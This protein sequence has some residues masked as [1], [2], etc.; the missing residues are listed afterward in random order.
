MSTSQPTK[1]ILPQVLNNC[2]LVDLLSLVKPALLVSKEIF[3]KNQ[4]KI[5]LRNKMILLALCKKFNVV[6]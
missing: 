5:L 2:S 4:S 6:L 3:S 1:N